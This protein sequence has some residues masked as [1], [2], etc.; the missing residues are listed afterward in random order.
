MSTNH[1]ESSQ[2]INSLH[3]DTVTCTINAPA[4][5]ATAIIE[6]TACNGVRHKLRCLIDQGSTES[7]ITESAAQILQLKRTKITA[8]ISGVGL[9][10]SKTKHMVQIS[11]KSTY[12]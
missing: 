6:V 4:L 8:I 2:Q 12:K 9:Q 11:I 3:S 5:L 7:F 10:S 1:I